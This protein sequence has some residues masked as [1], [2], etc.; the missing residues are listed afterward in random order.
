MADIVVIA[1][2]QTIAELVGE[3]GWEKSGVGITQ[4]RL[5]QGVAAA[6]EAVEAGARVLVSRGL[7]YR[8]ITDALP[9]IPSVEIRFSGYDILR[10]Y[11]QATTAEGRVAIVG[12]QELIEGFCSIEDI[13][14]IGGKIIKIEVDDDRRYNEEVS[15]A[16]LRGASCIIG[17]QAVV[18]E[19]GARGV[20]G[21]FIQS[22]RESVKLAMTSAQ[23]ALDQLRLQE[24]NTRQL[25]TII[26]A[27]DYGILAIDSEGGIT[28]INTEARRLLHQSGAGKDQEAAIVN[29][30][31]KSAGGNEKRIVMVERLGVNTEVVVNY[32]PIF[33][34]GSVGGMV[35]TLQEL[36][37]FQDIEQKTRRE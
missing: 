32:L 21:S 4:A 8:M 19:A 6:R 29:K 12:K 30:M 17:N 37:Q 7:T 13:L 28:A 23:A 22:G 11:L 27:V 35:A 16:I 1:P 5:E 15:Q 3:L 10:A 14:G 18:Q 20:R 24:A 36:K 33:L 2:Q 9:H 25:D 31:L 34:N 26:N